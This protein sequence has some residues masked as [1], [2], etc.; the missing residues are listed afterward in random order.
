MPS[1]FFCSYGTS[2]FECKQMI[3]SARQYLIPVKLFGIGDVWRGFPQKLI[4]MEKFV[5][6]IETTHGSDNIV[7]FVDAYDVIFN[8]TAQ[9]I[10][11]KFL[12]FGK[13]LVISAEKYCN[14]DNIPSVRNSYEDDDLGPFRY[15]NSGT[16]IGTV[17]AVKYF[18]K[19]C[20]KLS[21]NA[22]RIDGIHLR[23]PDD[24]RCLTT[25][26]LRHRFMCA[27][28]RQQKIFA[29]MAGLNPFDVL[30]Q[31]GEHALTGTRPSIIHLNGRSKRHKD[32]LLRF[33]GVNVQAS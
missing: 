15:V 16:Y 22:P 26:Y 20:H 13:P 27:L 28:D 6:A 7:C 31:T 2:K 11:A 3:L 1:I 21:Y 29:C 5:H 18:L 9:S 25:F 30:A 14:P 8:D 23:V 10:A 12:E 32:K 24:Q 33:I 4:A 19:W 17:Q